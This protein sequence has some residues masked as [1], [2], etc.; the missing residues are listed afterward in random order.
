MKD[1]IIVI[2]VIIILPIIH[3]YTNTSEHF[4]SRF[5]RNAAS[6]KQMEQKNGCNTGI[7]FNNPFCVYTPP[8]P[9]PRPPPPPPPPPVFTP[10]GTKFEQI[11]DRRCSLTTGIY[12]NNLND[13]LTKCSN[14]LNLGGFGP[15][16]GITKRP[17]GIYTG[18]VG[19][20]N[21]NL[22]VPNPSWIKTGNATVVPKPPP[23]STVSTNI[24]II[25]NGAKFEQLSN[26]RCLSN[27]G[28]FKG[29][30]DGALTWCS[31]KTEPDGLNSLGGLGP[32]IGVK[33]RTAG[34]YSGCI[35]TYTDSSIPNNSWIKT[36][37]AKPK[38]GVTATKIVN[39]GVNYD[40]ISNIRCNEVTG[41]YKG[42][43]DDV[44]NQCSNDKNVG[45]S[46]SSCIG[47]E[48]NKDGTYSGCLNTYTIDNSMPN[49]APNT[50]WIKR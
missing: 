18:C 5:K 2:I 19:T 50:T 35:D 16:V 29:T 32:C 49:T 21:N 10:N 44:L 14:A 30:L 31:N 34:T 6:T 28:T 8:S 36:G 1:Y 43:L 15:C 39:N 17:D 11:P 45:G 4:F 20:I 33:Q 9:P 38:P 40:Q 7:G 24:K 41:T 46:Q 12:T 23:P 47:V 26:V 42:T 22:P 13:S 27:T 25:P 3:V 48:Q 37:N